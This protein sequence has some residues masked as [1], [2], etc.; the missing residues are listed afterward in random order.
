LSAFLPANCP[1]RPAGV[2]QHLSVEAYVRT[3]N[4]ESK[5]IKVFC[6]FFSK[7]KCLLAEVPER[8]QALFLKKISKKHL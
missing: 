7:K 6:F 1:G 8:K 5:V 4:R 3:H 2:K